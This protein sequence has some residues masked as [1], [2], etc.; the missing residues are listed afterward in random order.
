MRTIDEL[1]LRIRRTKN[2][3]VVGLDTCLEYLPEAF[4]STLEM[5]VDTFEGAAKALLAYN[6]A[7]ID[8]LHDLIPA[9]KVQVAYYEM[10][11]SAGIQAFAK[12]VEYAKS[13]GLSVIADVK[14][15]DIGAT[16]QAYATAFTGETSLGE[17]AH[18]R[19]FC[20][21]FA[22]VTPYLGE[23]G[24]KPFLQ[25]CSVSGNGI[26]VLVKTS[27]PSS[28][29]LQDLQVDGRFI[30]EI[31]GDL[32][33]SWGEDLIGEEGYSAVGAVVGATYPEQGR[34]LRKRLPH[35]FFL[36]PGYGAQGAT[37]ADL[38]GCFDAQGGGAIVNASRSILC[39]W[40][41]SPTLSFSA[42]AR[43]EVIRMQTAIAA[44]LAAAGKSIA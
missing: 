42:A 14:R 35:T 4:L 28:G 21:D 37:G 18:A 40:K 6:C 1:I 24:I 27:N 44:G 11:G 38:S 25:T 5:P 39:A 41:S 20:P 12:T 36:V 33:A 30:Y 13:H 2:P 7:L 16:A 43:D 19:A 23:D 17:H 26:F 22:T 31:V 15:N 8:A 10:Y 3:T 29:Q 9:V 34:A 32:V